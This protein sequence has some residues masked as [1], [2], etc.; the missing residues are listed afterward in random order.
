[1]P[2]SAHDTVPEQAELERLAA[3][4]APYGLKAELC[5]P[6]GKL[7]YLQVSNPQATALTERVYA[8]ANAFWFSW[9]DRIADC[10]EP[11]TAAVTLARV[12]RTAE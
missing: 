1:M 5:T 9:A 2:T 12:L 11:S 8:Q 3:E 6:P 7:P 10:A 4:L